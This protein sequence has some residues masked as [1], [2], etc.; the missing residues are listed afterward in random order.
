VNYLLPNELELRQLAGD[1]PQDAQ[2]GALLAQG[3]G[4]LI[5][6][7]GERGSRYTDAGQSVS[8]PAVQNTVAEALAATGAGDCFNAGFLNAV[9]RGFAPEEALRAGNEIAF[10]KIT[11][12]GEFPG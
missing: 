5:L 2:V 11:N 3:C 9:L 1:Q 12:P 4:A 8:L 10:R 7:M 6:K